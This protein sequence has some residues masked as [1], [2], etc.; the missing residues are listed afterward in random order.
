MMLRS[1]DIM[2]KKRKIAIVS[3]GYGW[4]PCESGPSRFYYICKVFQENGYD[5]ELITT[6]FQHFE[7]KKRDQAKILSNNYPFKISFI[8]VPP[9]GKNIDVRRIFSNIKAAENTYEYLKS[10]QKKYDVVYCS[11]PSNRVAKMVGRYCH[12]NKIPFIVDIEDLWPE[13]ME[14]VIKNKLARKLLYPLKNDAEAVYAYA[15]AVIGTSDEYTNRAFKSQKRKI[16]ALTVYVGCDLDQFD[17][18]IEAHR[19]EIEKAYGERWII[20]TGSIG[21]SYNIDNLVRAAKLLEDEGRKNIKFK[22][23][24]TG[25]EKAAAEQLA[26]DLAVSNVEFL[27]YVAYPRM[28]AYLSK[29]DISVNSF[30]KGAPQSI[31][32]KVGDYL[33]AGKPII[34]TLESQEF[35][36]L[37]EDYN[38]GKNV[39]PGNPAAFRD[40]VMDILASDDYLTVCNNARQLAVSR[41]DRKTSYLELVKTADE[42]VGDF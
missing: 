38:V 18:G 14:M 29:S 19:D 10:V 33:A 42:L 2:E 37:V 24:G 16:K 34:N 31:V 21:T 22:I 25:P 15:D 5:V 13:A 39:E 11:I 23:L 32:N 40:A 6:G 1:S 28:A 35:C 9:Y 7:K 27:G 41:F 26:Q 36:K 17:A 30:V 3:L 4:L 20:Y 8:D 12:E